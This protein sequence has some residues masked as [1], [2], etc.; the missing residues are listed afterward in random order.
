MED[1]YL[2]IYNAAQ[3]RNYTLNEMKE[4]LQDE[5]I[6]AVKYTGY[7]FYFLE[8]LISSYPN[9]KF[10]TGADEA[11]L[12]GTAVGSDGA[13]GTTF[14]FYADKYIEAR[15]LFNKGKNAEALEI[16]HRL[17]DLTEAVVESGNKLLAATKYVMKLQGL[18][19]LP[20]SREP[21]SPLTDT[22]MQNLKAI[23]ERVQ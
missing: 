8:R 16:I 20:I 23:Y 2:M 13:I 1:L 10:Y 18:D 12:A 19:I 21:F 3:A 9:K 15:R 7:N 5:K 6:S 17:N 11:F 14:N 22:D 4:L